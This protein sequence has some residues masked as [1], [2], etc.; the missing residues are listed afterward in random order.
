[1]KEGSVEARKRLWALEG[2]VLGGD[3]KSGD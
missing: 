3:D 1:M 2:A